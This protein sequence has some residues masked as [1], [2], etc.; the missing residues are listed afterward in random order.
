MEE[1]LTEIDNCKKH[2]KVQMVKDIIYIYRHY[3]YIKQEKLA[4]IGQ[5]IQY[6]SNRF[7]ITVN[8]SF[9]MLFWRESSKRRNGS[10]RKQSCTVGR[11]RERHEDKLIETYQIKLMWKT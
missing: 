3:D 9:K 11:Q 10:V 8:A 6:I 1:E 5:D 2:I 7:S 4:Y